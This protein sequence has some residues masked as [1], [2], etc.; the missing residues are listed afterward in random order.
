MPYRY[1]SVQVL[2]QIEVAGH[3]AEPLLSLTYCADVYN[4]RS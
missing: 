3:L 4:I 2:L 1:A